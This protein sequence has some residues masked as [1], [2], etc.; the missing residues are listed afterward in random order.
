MFFTVSVG[1]VVGNGEF[2]VSKKGYERLLEVK[3]KK[4]PQLQLM[5][6][7]TE[8]FIY[9]LYDN[10]VEVYQS[11]INYFKQQGQW[12]ANLPIRKDNK[13]HAVYADGKYTKRKQG[14]EKFGTFSAA[15]YKEWSRVRALIKQRRSNHP[16]EVERCDKAMM[17]SYRLKNNITASCHEAQLKKN[18]QITVVEDLDLEQIVDDD[19]LG[20]LTAEV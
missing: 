7:S 10:M 2:P 15:G 18:N 16:K 14:T 9:I 19:W 8:A 20:E 13:E 4:Y 6:P 17:N 11:Q 1:K 5:T 3:C 12:F